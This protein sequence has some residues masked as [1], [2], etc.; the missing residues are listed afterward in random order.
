[1]ACTDYTHNSAI[2]VQLSRLVTINSAVEVDLT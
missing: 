2:L 1:M